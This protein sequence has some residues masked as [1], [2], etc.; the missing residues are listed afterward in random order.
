MPD[1][2]LSD[3]P[4]NQRAELMPFFPAQ[5]KKIL[6]VGCATGSFGKNLADREAYG[7]E[8]NEGAAVKARH[9]YRAVYHG[10]FP[11]AVPAGE[12]YDCIVFNDV[13]EHL[14]DPY[15]VLRRSRD[16]LRPQGLVFASIPN[17]RYL[18]V[19]KRLLVNADWRYEDEGVLDRTHLRYFT[20]KTMRLL[21]EDNGFEVKLIEPINLLQTWP[22]RVVRRVPGMQDMAAQQFVV[23][24]QRRP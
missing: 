11:E 6:D 8:P 24:G 20:S 16:F 17:V 1:L 5:A 18:R 22:G 7:L 3:Y 15:T 12:T 13:L 2:M 19:V 14:V 10:T 23:I 4:D 21:F 9:H